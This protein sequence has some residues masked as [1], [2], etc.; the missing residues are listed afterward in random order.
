MLLDLPG[1]LAREHPGL[2]RAVAVAPEIA[3]SGG[4]GVSFTPAGSNM[5]PASIG[6]PVANPLVIL[7][8]AA[9][10]SKDR[11]DLQA[12]RSASSPCWRAL[13]P[14]H[15]RCSAAPMPGLRSGADV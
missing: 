7:D 2:A 10:H 9:S 5:T 11:A 15:S 3:T 14:S 6:G 4:G 1:L 13:G 8:D 12:D